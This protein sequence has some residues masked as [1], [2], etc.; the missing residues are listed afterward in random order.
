[1][2]AY[3][4]ATL[5]NLHDPELMPPTLPRAHRAL[6]QAVDRLY[7]IRAFAPERERAGHLFMLYEKMPAPP[8]VGAR[9]LKR[10]R[11]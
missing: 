7:R 5:V 9:K 1:M 4:G 11:R 10:P 6:D 2:A 3:P 8:A